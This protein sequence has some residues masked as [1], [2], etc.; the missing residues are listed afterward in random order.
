MNTNVQN[1]PPRLIVGNGTLESLKWLGLLLMTGDHV[2]KYLFNG[3]L[4]FLFEAGRLAMPIFVF[5]LAYNLS[6]LDHESYK[7]VM[8]RLVFFGVISSIPFIAL[9]GLHSGWWPLN[10][11]FTLFSLTATLYFLEINSVV[12]AIL[13]FA[14]TGS[15]VEFYWPAILFGAAIWSYSRAPN[16]ISAGTAL[17][18]LLS[19]FIINRNLWALAVIPILLAARHIDFR[20][21]R[22]RWAFYA[23]YPFH[24]SAL[25]L[26]RIPMRNAGYLFFL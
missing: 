12:W 17:I 8:K 19:L 14:I 21:P 9:G 4:P 13:T 11:L 3:T 15:A 7:R 26:I 20:I 2:N 18:A 5:V 22:F 23:Y 10:I 24:L 25:W 16:L 1:K 6:R